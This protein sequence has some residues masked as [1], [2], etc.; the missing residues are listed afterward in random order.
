MGI[1]YVTQVAQPSALW[2]PRGVG[3]DG[4]WVVVEGGIS[5]G[6][7]H[8]Y[9]CDWFTLIYGR[10]HHNVVKQL[11]SI[12]NKE[13]KKEGGKKTVLDFKNK[14][15]AENQVDWKWPTNTL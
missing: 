3:W 2:Q 6:R 5:G 9:S 13:R 11:S 1:C 10:N 4:R 12:K 15:Y 7:G 14:K 8:M